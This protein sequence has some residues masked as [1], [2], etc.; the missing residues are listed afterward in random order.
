MPIGTPVTGS[1]GGQLT[2]TG[3]GIAVI[4]R[5]QIIDIGTSQL[6]S[7]ARTRRFAFPAPRRV[8]VLSYGYGLDVDSIKTFGAVDFVSV[9]TTT[10]PELTLE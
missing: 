4:R 5:N 10:D 1:P 8:V 3:T 6:I 2:P 7:S 9:I